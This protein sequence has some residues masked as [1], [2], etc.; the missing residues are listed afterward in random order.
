MAEIGEPV[1]RITVVPIERPVV[2]PEGPVRREI[3][4][5]VEPVEPRQP[6]KEPA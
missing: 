5:P 3:E 2:A 4:K 6:A 1:R